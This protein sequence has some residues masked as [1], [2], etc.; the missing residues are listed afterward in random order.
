ML[1]GCPM[2]VALLAEGEEKEEAEEVMAWREDD[3]KLACDMV[4]FCAKHSH[5]LRLLRCL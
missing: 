4:E 5:R 3:W 2:R 1:K